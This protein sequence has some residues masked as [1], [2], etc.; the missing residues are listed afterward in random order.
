VTTEDFTAADWAR[1]P[2]DH[3]ARLANRIVNEVDGISPVVYDI[4]SKPPAAIEWE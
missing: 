2:H 1:L 4:E 3:L